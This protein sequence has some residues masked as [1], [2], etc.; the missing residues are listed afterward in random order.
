MPRGESRHPAPQATA[1]EAATAAARRIMEAGFTAY[2]AGGCV[3]DELLGIEPTDYDLATDAKPDEIATLFRGSR[4]VGESFGVMLVR[5]RGRV[6]E[7]ATFRTDGRYED[8]RRPS[9]VRFAS[10]A[11]DAQRRDFTINGLFRHPLT[12]EIVDFVKGQQ[13][14]NARVLRAIGD[15]DARLREDRLRTLRAA[16]FAARFALTIDP[17]TA[18]AIQLAGE[19]LAGVSRERIGGEFRRMLTHETRVRALELIEEWKLDRAT[20]GEAPSAG[21]LIRVAAVHRDASFATALAAW[22]LDRA[23]RYGTCSAPSCE[24]WRDRLNLSARESSDLEAIGQLVAVLTTSWPTLAVAGRKR[25][26]SRS[27]FASSLAIL[28]AENPRLGLEIGEAAAALSKQHGG[29][30][31]QPFVT[32]SDLIGMGCA[33]CPRFKPFL[34]SLYDRQLDGTIASRDEALGVA[35]AEWF[36]H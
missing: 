13:D 30:A 35:R 9:H 29:L 21:P 24:T 27:V 18:L 2:F 28:S 20:L 25:L 1:K 15:P 22:Q 4:G 32:G 31:P 6:T 3:R 16:R 10:A 7:V 33:P 19:D 14:L 12:N 34:D 8:G 17:A 36:S 11:E 26:A 5:V 23:A